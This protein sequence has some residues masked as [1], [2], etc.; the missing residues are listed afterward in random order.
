RQAAPLPFPAASAGIVGPSVDAT[1]IA[2]GTPPR[3]VDDDAIPWVPIDGVVQAAIEAAKLPGCVIVVGRHDDIL[4][5]RAYGSRALVPER[6]PMTTETLFD[7]ASLTKPI[8]TATSIKILVDRGKIDLEARASAYVPELARLPPFTVRQLLVHTSGLPAATPLS[9]WTTDRAEVIRHIGA[10]MLKAQPGERF[11]YSDVGYVVLQEIVQRVAGKELAA[12]AAEE[13]F[14]PLGMKETGF[15]PPPE[16]RVRAAPTEQRDGGFII[17]EV[18][19]PRAFALGGV[20]GHA[21]VF[22]TGRDMSRFARA[23]LERGALDDHRLFGPKTFERFIARQNTSKGGRTLGWDLDSTFATH[24]SALFSTKAFGHG[25]YTGTA[26]W[27]DPERDL[28][29]VFLSNRVHPDGKGA[30][31]PLVAEIATLA[32][33]ASEVKTGIDVLRAESFARLHG[34]RVGLIT[35]ATTKAKDGTGTIDAFRH[36]PGVTLGA[37]FTPEHGISGDREGNIPDA[38]YEGVPVHSL[39]GERFGP[40]SDT[41]DGIDTLVFDLQ[42]VGMRFYTYA[43]TMKRAMKV[44][45]EKHLRF[46]VLDRPNPIGGVEVQGPV[47]AGTDVKGFV[48]HHPLPL[49]HGMTIGEL[50]RL[51]AADDKLEM[52]LEIVKMLG[53]RRKD[54]YDRTGLAWAAPSPNLR[55]LRSVALYPAI[56]LLESTNVSVGRGTDTPFEVVAAPWM[57]GPLV[58]KKLNESG[59]AGAV[60]EPTTV[61]PKSSVHANKKCRGIHVRVTDPSRFEPVRTAV[62]IANVLRDVHPNDWDFDGMDKMLRYPPAMDAIRAG[63]GLADIEATWALPLGLFKERRAQFLLYK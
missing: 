13:I 11:N 46:V 5:E 4:F 58:A 51:F 7:L 10:L 56:G 25:G 15:L 49:R 39:Y 30:V 24:R 60:F 22:S 23:M 48:N 33:T 12:F 19:D 16:L 47:L 50:A 41:L 28:F 63:K 52:R 20:S 17:G 9:D 44:A 61:T 18:H 14:A 27:I 3:V 38:R 59:I 21:G 40:T 2:T 43:A 35:N 29:V 54:P 1:P 42:D 62:T 36:A 45:T 32:V 8:A 6:V 37:I 55:S 31:N 34:A 57:D 53:W 26:M